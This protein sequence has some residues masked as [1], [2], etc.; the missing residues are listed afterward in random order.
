MALFFSM[1]PAFW[2][3]RINNTVASIDLKKST[4]I[5]ENSASADYS[6][7][8][9]NFSIDAKTD[10]IMVELLMRDFH[11]SRLQALK[12]LEINKRKLNLLIEQRT[13]P[14]LQNLWND[15]FLSQKKTN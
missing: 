1:L 4:V 15:F 2:A 12:K 3:R 9:F 8:W 5:S 7:D 14:D 13:Q 10:F 6:Q 11:L